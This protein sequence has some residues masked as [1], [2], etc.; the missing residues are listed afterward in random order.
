VHYRL[1]AIRA[2][3]CWQLSQ[4]QVSPQLQTSPH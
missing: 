1:S 2:F 4:V 3:A